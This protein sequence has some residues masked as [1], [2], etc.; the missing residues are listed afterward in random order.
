MWW[1]KHWIRACLLCSQGFPFRLKNQNR[2]FHILSPEHT[3]KERLGTEN[4]DEREI[5]SCLT[6][7]YLLDPLV[8]TGTKSSMESIGWEEG[9]GKIVDWDRK[10]EQENEGNKRESTHPGEMYQSRGGAPCTLLPW[11][12]TVTSAFCYKEE[13]RSKAQRETQ[14]HNS[15][16][17]WFSGNLGAAAVDFTGS[18]TTLTLTEVTPIPLSKAY[19][20]QV[21]PH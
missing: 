14:V 11:H 13:E 21:F 5:L 8:E 20:K 17:F 16:S 10:L 15:H 19:W 6:G 12:F 2:Q 18:P 1:T 9:L 7:Q 4:D 3:G